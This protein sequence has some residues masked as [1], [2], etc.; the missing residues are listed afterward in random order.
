MS[1][2]INI[3]VTQLLLLKQL[4]DMSSDVIKT[5]E[6]LFLFLVCLSFY[7]FTFDK[8]LIHFRLTQSYQ[9]TF[10]VCITVEAPYLNTQNILYFLRITRHRTYTPPHFLVDGNKELNQNINF[11]STIL[12]F[13]SK[14]PPHII[15]NN[16][17]ATK[18]RFS[19][20]VDFTQ[21]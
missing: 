20:T 7:I 11:Y 4:I 15:E 21:P 9:N 17:C 5:L 18:Y 12:L 14:N 1:M 13:S 19:T 3:C 16:S 8:K 10:Q 2:F 6:F